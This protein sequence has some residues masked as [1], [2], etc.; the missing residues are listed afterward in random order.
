MVLLCFVGT[1][2]SHEM[3]LFFSLSRQLLKKT[4]YICQISEK[5]SSPLSI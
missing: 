1:K 3:Y 5:N 4:E 2:I